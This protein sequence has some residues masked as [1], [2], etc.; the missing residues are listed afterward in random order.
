[1]TSRPDVWTQSASCSTRR[2]FGTAPQLAAQRNWLRALLAM[3]VALHV[4]LVACCL[5]A[6]CRGVDLRGEPFPDDHLSRAGRQLRVPERESESFAFSNK[7]RQIE[8]N[9]GIGPDQ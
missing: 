8:R 4:S 9:L 1:M 2:N 6:G 3:P 7:A 5:I